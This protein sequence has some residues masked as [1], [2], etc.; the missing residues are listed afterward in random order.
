MVFEPAEDTI[1][2]W[3][4]G[5][6]LGGVAGDIELVGEETSECEAGGVGR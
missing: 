1:L 4:G 5:P 2:I 6:R 3:V